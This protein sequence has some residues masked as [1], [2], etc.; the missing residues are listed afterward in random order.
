M[1]H[2][3]NSVWQDIRY[4]ATARTKTF[5][6]FQEAMHPNLRGH[7]L[8]GACLSAACAATPRSSVWSGV[9]VTA[10]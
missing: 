3:D 2:A 8:L 9:W 1:L 5:H 6:V 10:Y 4:T 7:Q